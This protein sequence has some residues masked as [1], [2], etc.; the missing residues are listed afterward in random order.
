VN[1]DRCD[2]LEALFVKT[3]GQINAL[4][5]ELDETHIA[6]AGPN[7]DGNDLEGHL[8]GWMYRDSKVQKI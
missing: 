1:V 2:A 8:N 6:V 3:S 5:L 4:K 7:Q